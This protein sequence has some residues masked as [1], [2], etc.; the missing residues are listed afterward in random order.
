MRIIKIL[1][2]TIHFTLQ[3]INSFFNSHYH[4]D[5]TNFWSLF[6]SFQFNLI[7]IKMGS[8]LMEVKITNIDFCCCF[9]FFVS[10]L[11][12]RYFRVILKICV[13]ILNKLLMDEMW[14]MERYEKKKQWN[15]WIVNLILNIR[16]FVFTQTKTMRIEV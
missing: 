4:L 16:I 5:I 12:L 9:F 15:S 1:W 14:F 8:N 2:L 6:V 7:T 10:L 3:K 11:L 13:N